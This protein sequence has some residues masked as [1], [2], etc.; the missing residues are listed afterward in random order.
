MSAI[1]YRNN[2][3]G[4]GGSGGGGGASAISELTD[5]DLD[6]LSDGQILKW[7]ATMQKWENADESGGGGSTVTITPTLSTGTKIADF[8]VDGTPG[9][10]YA[11]TGGGGGGSGY[12][13]TTLFTGSIYTTAGEIT[14]NDDIDN[15]D[16]IVIWTT[17]SV[18]SAQGAVPFMVDTKYFV[19]TF[20]YNNGSTSAADPHLFCFLYT[21][22]Y[23]RIR[24]GSAKN[25]L[26]L[27]DTHTGA[28]AKV[29]GLKYSG[30]GSG[31][32]Y[33]RTE[34]FKSS[35]NLAVWDASGITLSDDIENY[36][37]I[38]FVLAFASGTDMS[39]RTNKFGA[40]WFADYC[41]YTSA[42]ASA[43]HALLL[44]WPSHGFS[45][46]WDSANQKIMMWG[47][48][49][50]AGLYAVYGIKY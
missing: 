30:G 34:L 5:V 27:F 1:M 38:E 16:Q 4:A 43:D 42:A 40:K 29:T 10:L 6:N 33:S 49:G 41:G 47:R 45:A 19:E 32:G 35:T 11:P 44:L 7:N 13:E 26:F 22:Q 28:V 21:N 14:L 36:D 3:Y 2:V 8:E 12:T 18:T 25:K 37:E 15:Y 23:I 31:G 46:A 9:E 20:L 24:C 39:K 17:W 50:S 48:N